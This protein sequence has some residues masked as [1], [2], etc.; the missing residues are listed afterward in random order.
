MPYANITGMT[1]GQDLRLVLFTPV[2]IAG[3]T[4]GGG[5][6]SDQLGRLVGMN[7]SPVISEIARVPL[8]NGGVRLVRNIYQ[9]WNG[10]IDLVRYNGN[11]SLLMASIMS[12]FNNLGNESYFNIEAAVYNVI[13]QT[14]DTYTFLNCVLSQVNMGNFG[15]TNAVDQRLHF[16]GQNMLVNGQMPTGL[17]PLQQVGGGP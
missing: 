2:S 16:E 3:A 5:F 13:T 11:A 4:S 12:I 8:D 1:V 7:A 17:P 9:G 6:T 15:E 10:D 14:T